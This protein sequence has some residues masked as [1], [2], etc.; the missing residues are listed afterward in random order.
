MIVLILLV[1]IEEG[2]GKT[3]RA[4]PRSGSHPFVNVP[5]GS[6]LEGHVLIAMQ[7]LVCFSFGGPFYLH[8]ASSDLQ[9]NEGR[10][11]LH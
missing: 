7:A 3:L 10:G 1:V 9:Q 5:N 2:R 4:R 8:I 11:W 6:H